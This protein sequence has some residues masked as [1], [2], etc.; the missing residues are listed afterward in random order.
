M[1]AMFVRSQGLTSE[2]QRLRVNI[3]TQQKPIRRAGLQYPASVSA[4]AQSAIHITT[5]ALRLQCVY[6]LLIKYRYMCHVG[7]RG[8]PCGCPLMGTSG[9]VQDL[10]LRRW[11]R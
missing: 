4:R 1:D 11:F 9:Q 6:N 3:Q 10:P 8:W 2:R 5:T 7:C